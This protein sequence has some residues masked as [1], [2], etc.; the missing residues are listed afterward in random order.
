MQVRIADPVP[1]SRLVPRLPRDLETICLKCC[2]KSRRNATPAPKSWRTIWGVIEPGSRLRPVRSV[3]SSDSPS[4]RGAGR[5]PQ[6]L[7]C[8]RH[9][10]RGV[11]VSLIVVLEQLRETKAAQ[12]GRALARVKVLR[13]AAPVPSQ[14]FLPNP[15]MAR[16][17]VLSRL[18]RG[19]E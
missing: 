9:P 4:G 18:A 10:V 11:V 19:V 1:P 6:R 8:G 15:D 7:G 16:D 14:A 2:G 17:D 5:P 13:E 12:T 3:L